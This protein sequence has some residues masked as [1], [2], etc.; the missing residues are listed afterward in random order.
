[1]PERADTVTGVRVNA[2]ARVRGAWS[3]VRWVLGLV[4]RSAR[5]EVLLICG[6]QVV[7]A[8]GVLVQLLVAR[9]VI[10]RVVEENAG[11]VDL[12]PLIVPL[13]LSL[14]A[15]RLASA[16]E[17]D[18]SELAALIVD[19]EITDAVLRI[20]SEVPLEQFEDP[21]FH[22]EVH[23][24]LA[25]AIHRPYS[26]VHA[27]FGLLGTV[28]T[29]GAVVAAL[30]AV[31]PIFLLV[32][33][34]AYVPLWIALRRSNRELYR[35]AYDITPADR[36]RDYLKDVLTDPR[37][38]AEAR[39][40]G[41]GPSFRA[42]HDDLYSRR[43]EVQR[44]VARRRLRRALISRAVS[45]LVAGSL[46]AL[47]LAVT[48][49]DG[50]RIAD[51]VVSAVAL[52]QLASSFS[53]GVSS[54]QELDEA[55]PYLADLQRL[56]GKLPEA[57]AEPIEALPPL[58]ELRL[59]GVSFRYPTGTV[60][61]VRDLD[62]V[63]RPGTVTAIVGENGVGKTTLAKVLCG[64]YAPTSGRILWNG[65]EIAGEDRARLTASGSTL[66]QDFARYR[67]TVRRNVGAGDVT[68]AAEG[69][70]LDAALASSTA[71]EVVEELP[72][73]AD[74]MLGITFES[75]TELSSGQWQR[76]ALARALFRTSAQVL[77]LDEP[78][79][80]LDATTERIVFDSLRSWASNRV[81]VV[82]TH[83]PI[84]AD[85]VDEVLHHHRGVHHHAA[86]AHGEIV[87]AAEH[88]GLGDGRE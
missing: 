41:L 33:V 6:L 78:T 12:L 10:Q 71:A 1:M 45:A 69:P 52:Q 9:E 14:A 32:G 76:L 49:G 5:R 39:G 7:S 21:E 60:D 37:P 38:A 81:V 35:L 22:D 50:L 4:M 19:R 58:E 44:G 16:A 84:E 47:I 42:R 61:V 26:L 75:G 30:S 86:H 56:L 23:R 20:T 15:V 77:V 74:T 64:L 80:S 66:F 73:G 72:D 3:T 24:V 65:Q 36:E 83:R 40:Y 25:H 54:L 68:L 88:H 18:R 70:A 28:L 29:A 31:Q 11:A 63:L 51:I 55:R 46:I 8:I 34:V 67:M 87:E 82:I 57:S 48:A 62:L 27:L 13:A 53:S 43:I 17:P 79:S 85:L 59:E 2:L